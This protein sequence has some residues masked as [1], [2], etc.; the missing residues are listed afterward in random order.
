MVR[1]RTEE[2]TEVHRMGSGGF[3][4]HSSGTISLLSRFDEIDKLSKF[5]FQKHCPSLH[6]R[7]LHFHMFYTK[8]LS[9]CPAPLQIILKRCCIALLFQY[10]SLFVL[11]FF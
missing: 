9:E 1:H 4:G 5:I 3:R 6:L 8:L 10:A 11:I 7:I 2:L